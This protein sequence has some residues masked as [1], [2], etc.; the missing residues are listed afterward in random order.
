MSIRNYKI[1]IE[2]GGKT[3]ALTTDS[4]DYTSIIQDFILAL[5]AVHGYQFDVERIMSEISMLDGCLDRVFGEG[6]D[7]ALE[8]VNE[9]L[10]ETL[11]VKTDGISVFPLNKTIKLYNTNK[12]DQE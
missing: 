9:V 12:E 11:N 6:F 1:T 7:Q 2:S 10:K 5:Q 3:V 4:L 8:Q